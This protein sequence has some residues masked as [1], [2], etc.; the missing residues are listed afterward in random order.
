MKKILLIVP[1][2]T[3]EWGTK[4]AGG[5]DSVCQILIQEL[6]QRSNSKFQYRILAFDPF[7][8]VENC[9]EIINLSSHV[10]VV[11]FH[12][13]EKRW[14]LKLPSFISNSL[15]V[16]AQIKSFKPDVVHAHIASWLLG[17]S[18]DIKRVAT[19][20]SYKN[21]GRKPVS[22]A[23]DFLYTKLMPIMSNLYI[24]CYS[25]V[26]NIIKEPLSKTTNKAISVIGNPIHDAFFLAKPK[27]YS[28]S[29]GIKLITC[30]LVNRKK[31][32]HRAIHLVDVLNKAKI[33]VSLVVIGPCIDKAYFLEL[34]SQIK[35]LGVED[36]IEFMGA[37]PQQKIVSEYKSAHIGVFFSSEETFGLAPLEMLASGLPLFTTSVGILS[38]L[39]QAFEPLGV[40]YWDNMTEQQHIEAV[41][42][43]Q[44]LD[45]QDSID[46]VKHNFLAKNVLN[47]YE[48]LY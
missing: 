13:N 40:E 47:A 48:A 31:C 19:L 44:N 4:N 8:K 34:K 41:L 23:N 43:L 6:S 42:R 9:G 39:K 12:A 46:Y 33:E 25:C 21:I 32:I 7:S 24:D 37:Q 11:F 15:R 45:T 38:E 18:S 30:A 3:I 27:S 2:S 26:G 14:G 1:L 22:W 16:L 35:Q 20:H 5:V 28:G 10:E 29:E 36:K 17:V